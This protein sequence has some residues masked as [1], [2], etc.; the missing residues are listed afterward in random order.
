MKSKKTKYQ[1]DGLNKT[2]EDQII[3]KTAQSH[4]EKKD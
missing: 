4:D 1:N 2:S 3:K